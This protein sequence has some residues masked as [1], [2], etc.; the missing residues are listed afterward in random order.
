[1]QSGAVRLKKGE[2]A[3]LLKRIVPIRRF[4]EDAENNEVQSLT[5]SLPNKTTPPPCAVQS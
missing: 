2:A 3:N 1:M 5:P 4:P